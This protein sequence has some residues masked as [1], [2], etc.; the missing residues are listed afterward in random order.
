MKKKCDGA[1][2]RIKKPEVIRSL[3]R[4]GIQHSFGGLRQLV[5]DRAGACFLST[6]LN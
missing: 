4:A 1:F 5:S 6:A 3:F 2:N